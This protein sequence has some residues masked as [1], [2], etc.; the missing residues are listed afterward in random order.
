MFIREIDPLIPISPIV[1]CRKFGSLIQRTP[2]PFPATRAAQ[3]SRKRHKENYYI[4]IVFRLPFS[5]VRFV[6][7]CG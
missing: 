5:L 7:F 3:V 2:V 1:L 6:P 4:K